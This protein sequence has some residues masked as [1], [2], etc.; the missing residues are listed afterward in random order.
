MANLEITENY[1]LVATISHSGMLYDTKEKVREVIQFC[2][3][4]NKEYYDFSIFDYC[5]LTFSDGY[6]LI[7]FGKNNTSFITRVEY[8]S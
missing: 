1:C 4:T 3:L 5:Y 6:F 8:N 7:Y 2:G